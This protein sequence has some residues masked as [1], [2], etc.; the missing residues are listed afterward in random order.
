MLVQMAFQ[1][2]LYITDRHTCFSVE[3]RNR[4][5]P[6]KVPHSQISKAERHRPPRKGVE[7]MRQLKGAV[8]GAHWC[9]RQG[10][11]FFCMLTSFT[12]KACDA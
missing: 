7:R 9:Q 3:E 1:G 12:A 5:M 2:T 8:V 4:K 6:F 11:A 10:N